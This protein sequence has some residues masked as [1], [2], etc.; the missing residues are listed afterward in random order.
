M[1]EHTY[2]HTQLSVSM[3]GGKVQI[4][5]KYKLRNA[6]EQTYT[7]FFLETSMERYKF[8]NIKE[9]MYTTVSR[10]K[11]GNVQ[12]WKYGRADIH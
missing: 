12:V 5:N 9:Q 7:I 8:G 3:H 4:W 1:E 6:E 11:Y 10:D 2:T